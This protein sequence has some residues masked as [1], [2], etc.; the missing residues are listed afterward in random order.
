MQH[1]RRQRCTRVFPPGVVQSC[2]E[3]RALV[4]GDG[5]LMACAGGIS[6]AAEAAKRA[7]SGT[8]ARPIDDS[9]P[10]ATA[11]AA[12]GRGSDGSAASAERH[13]TTGAQSKNPN[14]PSFQKVGPAAPSVLVS[15]V[16][17]P[18]DCRQLAAS[19]IISSSF[20]ALDTVCALHRTLAP[21]HDCLCPFSQP[22]G[23]GS[24]RFDMQLGPSGRQVTAAGELLLSG[25]RRGL[26]LQELIT[27]SSQLNV[28]R[29]QGTGC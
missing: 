15:R 4:S 12:A 5:L 26:M 13:G 7:R 14:L 11:S 6:A 10:A 29:L 9:A 19:T 22:A 21:H 20:A 25:G 3:G 27:T 23:P 1:P 2:R 16:E 28:D 8:A 18:A 17:K 24:K